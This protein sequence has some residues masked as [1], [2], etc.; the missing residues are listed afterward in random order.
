MATDY[1]NISSILAEIAALLAI[2]KPPDPPIATPLILGAIDRPGLSAQ[3][4]GSEIIRKRAEAGLPVGALPD[5][6]P[7]PAELLEIIRA[8]VYIKYL[9]TMMRTSVAIEPGITIEGY[10]TD[11]MG[12][13]VFVQGITTGIGTGTAIVQ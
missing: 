2:P 3:E 13:P 4:I 9:T 1:T 10:G 11:A 6:K 8:E 12:S 5:G 7:N